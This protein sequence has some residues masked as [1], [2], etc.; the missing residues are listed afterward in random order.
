LKSFSRV[1]LRTNRYRGRFPVEFDPELEKSTHID[2]RREDTKI[3]CVDRLRDVLGETGTDLTDVER[4]VLKHRFAITEDVNLDEKPMTLE[5]V[6]RVIG[7]T[8]ERVRQIQNKALIKLRH[9]L[10]ENVLSG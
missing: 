1:A 4:Q 5:D 6:G 2:Q 9:L 3:H 7:V 10:E 8:K